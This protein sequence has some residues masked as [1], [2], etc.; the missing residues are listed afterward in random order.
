MKG[1]VEDRN[2]LF[3][4]ML[5]GQML[6]IDIILI[7]TLKNYPVCGGPGRFLVKLVHLEHGSFY[8][9]ILIAT[10]LVY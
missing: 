4:E 5:K 1:S 3:F 8:A 10:V 9:I 2:C 7:T 6:M